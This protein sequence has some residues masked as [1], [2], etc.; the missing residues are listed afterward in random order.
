M[1]ENRKHYAWYCK[2]PCY[3]YLDDNTVIGRNLVTT[4][5]VGILVTIEVC[6]IHILQLLDPFFEFQGFQFELGEKV[7]KDND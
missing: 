1:D 2:I 4:I 7:K 5:L 6:A 3:L